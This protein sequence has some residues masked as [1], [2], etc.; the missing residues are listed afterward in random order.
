M[1]T[2]TIREACAAQGSCVISEGTMDPRVVLPRLLAALEQL[3]P[4]AHHQLTQPGSGLSAIPAYAMED[5]HSDWWDG[6]DASAVLNALVGALNEAAPEGFFFGIEGDMRQGFYRLD[7]P[8][9]GKT[10]AAESR[11][12]SPRMMPGQA[13][14]TPS[15]R[16][17]IGDLLAGAADAEDLIDADELEEHA[18]V[19]RKRRGES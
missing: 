2:N 8:A 12:E 13:P 4:A 19:A 15:E 6:D 11:E 5:E 9:P 7:P 10:D 3:S 18:R 16:A 17:A 14:Y 1:H